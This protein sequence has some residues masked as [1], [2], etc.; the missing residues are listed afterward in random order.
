[1]TNDTEVFD[2]LRVD[3]LTG[4]TEWTKRT[5][6]R[7]AI[8]RDGLIIAPMSWGF[9]PHEWIDGRGYVDLELSRKHPYPHHNGDART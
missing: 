3:R 2:A 1:M 4:T 7:E 6:T 9:C 5:G 8:H